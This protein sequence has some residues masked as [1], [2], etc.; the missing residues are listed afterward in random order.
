MYKMLKDLDNSI[1]ANTDLGNID[2]DKH[3]IWNN[4]YQQRKAYKKRYTKS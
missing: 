4:K 2:L 3:F 1:L